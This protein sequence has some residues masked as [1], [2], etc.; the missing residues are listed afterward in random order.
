ML[1]RRMSDPKATRRSIATNRKARHE[2]LL[3]DELEC[4]IALLGTEVKSL[5]AG[6][7]SLAEA[8][9]R[10]KGDELWLL[11]ANIPEYSHGNVHNHAP[12]RDR[13]LLAKKRE[14]AKWSK[15]VREKGV[16]IVP[17]E[18]F[19]SGS[20]VKVT[21]ALAKGKKLYDKRAS[22]RERSDKRD[23]ARAAGRRR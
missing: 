4:G 15:A 16:T 5:R 8:Y 7:C 12:T 18:V 10:I 9:G 6:H 17:L 23:M 21:V 13:K 19:W 22:E 2:Y 11:G 14:I 20:L 3:L 1:R